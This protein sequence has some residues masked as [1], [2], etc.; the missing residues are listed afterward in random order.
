MARGPGSP[1]GP[2]SS[3][4]ARELLRA[5]PKAHC[6]RKRAHMELS[7]MGGAARIRLPGAA[8][9]TQHPDSNLEQ[10]PHCHCCSWD[11]H[12]KWH[13]ILAILLRVPL[14]SSR[15][16]VSSLSDTDTKVNKGFEQKCLHSFLAWTSNKIGHP[17][18]Y[19][20]FRSYPT[21]KPRFLKHHESSWTVI[22]TPR[23]KVPG[24]KPDYPR[25]SVIIKTNQFWALSIHLLILLLPTDSIWLPPNLWASLP[26]CEGGRGRSHPLILPSLGIRKGSGFVP[27][28]PPVSPWSCTLFGAQQL[29]CLKAKGRP[30]RPE[31]PNR[32]E[33]QTSPSCRTSFCFH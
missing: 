2:A 1:A 33:P 17:P 14:A 11:P 23:E 28:P 15:W 22:E 32:T 26:C 3:I 19:S 9:A 6:T 21:R 5:E 16:S 4:P 30:G 18:R 7:W 8:A 13:G 12:V 27:L 10:L 24:G 20:G 25:L 29:R 31:G